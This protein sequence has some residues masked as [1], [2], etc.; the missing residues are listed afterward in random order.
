MFSGRDVIGTFMFLSSRSF[1]SLSLT[2]RSF[3]NLSLT[4]LSTGSADFLKPSGS[5]GK[6]RGLDIDDIWGK[7]GLRLLDDSADDSPEFSPVP[8]G[9]ADVFELVVQNGARGINAD[10]TED[11]GRSWAWPSWPLS[12]RSRI[13]VK[14]IGLSKLECSEG[15]CFTGFCC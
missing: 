3:T 13:L 8:Y 14:S 9:Y 10:E 2:S 12:I 11:P 1:T 7:E 4:N 15:S 5:Y 6:Y